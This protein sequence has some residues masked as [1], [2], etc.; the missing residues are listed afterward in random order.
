M[1]KVPE[2]KIQR[3][4]GETGIPTV[5]GR[6]KQFPELRNPD[7]RNQ[8]NGMFSGPRPTY[9]RYGMSPNAT[10]AAIRGRRVNP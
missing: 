8:N 6:S 2:N 10:D 4:F 9:S 3:A 1:A 5:F 7:I